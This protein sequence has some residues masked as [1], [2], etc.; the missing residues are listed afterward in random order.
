[1]KDRQFEQ[2]ATEVLNRGAL[3]VLP[4]NLPDRWLNALLEEAEI[5]QEGDRHEMEDT[6][7]GL[8]GS[9]ILILSEQSGHPTEME[10]AASTLLRYMDY[11]IITLS[12]E[13]VSRKTDIWVEPPTLENIF[14]EDREMKAM[15][16]S[17]GAP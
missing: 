17:S 6:C 16:K 12:A 5:L 7:A 1:M 14:Q 15:R 10:V 13:M 2:F 3:A 9:V 11:Y 4:Q 8:L